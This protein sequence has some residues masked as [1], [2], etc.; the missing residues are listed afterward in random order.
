VL[1]NFTSFCFAGE[2]AIIGRPPRGYPAQE[3]FEDALNPH[4]GFF[5]PSKALR[6]LISFLTL[7]APHLGQAILGTSAWC[8][9]NVSK[10]CP[11]PAH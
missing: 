6:Q 8:K 2:A 9:T 4:S 3:N 5:A 10:Q 7:P 1:S 11:Q